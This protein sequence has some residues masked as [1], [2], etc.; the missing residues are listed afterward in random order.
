MFEDL[1]NEKNISKE[2]LKDTIKDFR[3][4]LKDSKKYIKQQ[5]D[6]Y[7]ELKNDYDEVK[8]DAGRFARYIKKIQDRIIENDLHDD[9]S[10]IPVP[11]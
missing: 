7:D 5:Q 2:K 4:L 11:E 3:E 6:Q 8:Q 10:D 1:K 9:F